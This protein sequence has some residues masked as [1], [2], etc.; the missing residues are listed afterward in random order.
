M[1]VHGPY[2][3]GEPRVAREAAVAI[4]EG[5][6][7]DVI[8]MRRQGEPAREVVDGVHAVRLPLSH[9]RDLGFAG[10]VLEYVAYTISASVCVARRHLRRPYD[11]V[12][13]HNPPD[14][15]ISAALV[16]K[17][18]GARVIFDV[19]D[20]SAHMFGA[21]F[22]AGPAR[23]GVEALLRRVQ[24]FAGGVADAVLTVHEPYRR[25]LAAEGIVPE[26]ITVVMNS[27]DER[28]LPSS[29]PSSG[30]GPFRVVYHGTITPSYGLELLVK[31]A[32][33]LTLNR[34]FTF[35]LYGE[36]DAVEAI[37]HAADRLGISDRF[38]ISGSYL[39]H[40][41]VLEKVAGASVGVIPNLPSELNR[42]ALSSKLFEYVAMEIP[43][44]SA[45]LP[46]IREHFS[47][48]E[49]RF[50]RAGDAASLAE[51]L[52]DVATDPQAAALRAE[53]ARRRYA[54]YRWPVQSARY[55]DV[56]GALADE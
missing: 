23:S 55:A 44:I 41:E 31:A 29:S 38:R 17:L 2:P 6:E 14:F 36:G 34:D 52:M 8:A 50:F 10:F 56:L 30:D 32:V 22:H 16:P 43:V 21:R 13:V 26:S 24:R 12:H 49:L 54:E 53:R 5:F 46:T 35:E 11:V 4:A 40:G 51:A 15:L 28:L 45:D 19:H 37:R 3:V 42:F 7:V 33:Q 1:I 47:D 48:D 20:L 9:R 39:P 27:V 18:L 25:A